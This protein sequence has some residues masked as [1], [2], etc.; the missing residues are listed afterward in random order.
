[1][2]KT[3]VT[4]ATGTLG[5]ALRPRLTAAGHTVQAASR[6]PPRESE[7]GVEWVELDL[8]EDTA[9]ESALEHVDVVVHAATAPRSNTRA[10]DVAG[11]KRLLEA[12]AAAGV[13]NFLYPSIVGVG[14]IP[15]SY[16][17]HKAVVE[18]AIGESEV[19]S[20]IVPVTQFHSFI[21][22]LLASVAKLPV[23]PLPTKLQLQPVAVG[24][25]AD[26]IVDRA[27]LAAGGRTDPIGGPEVH[28]AGEL[29]RM[30]REAR[31]L[32]RPIVR[33]PLPGDTAAGFR[34]GHATCPDHRV[35]TV[36]WGEWLAEQHSNGTNES[37]AR[38]RSPT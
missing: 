10:V 8:A 24:E 33:I 27:T 11:T 9:I 13:E 5:T 26:G 20:T 18:T 32:R 7:S 23:W 16:Y 38:R 28:S 34:A 14:T 30:Y 1:M 36:T 22:D 4:G 19:P 37:N 25:V 12:A 15:F 3:L 2:I 17:E 35:G 31:G 6:S 29:A 21:T